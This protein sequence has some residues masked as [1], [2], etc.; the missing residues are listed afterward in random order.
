[1]EPGLSRS[2]LERGGARFD[3]FEPAGVRRSPVRPGSARGPEREK[4]YCVLLKVAVV[5]V[6]V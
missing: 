4:R 2:L 3:P 6:V 1:M 5:A